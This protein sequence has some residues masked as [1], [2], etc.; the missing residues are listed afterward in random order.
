MQVVAVGA[1]YPCSVRVHEVIGSQVG[2]VV[3][4]GLADVEL[5]AHQPEHPVENVFRAVGVA[6]L[7]LEPGQALPPK[8]R[9]HP[10]DRRRIG[11]REEPVE[12]PNGRDKGR[13]HYLSNVSEVW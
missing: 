2:A 9:F 4:L 10:N 5:E 12:K 1:K 8:Q 7:L 11:K 6:E 13:T 3:P